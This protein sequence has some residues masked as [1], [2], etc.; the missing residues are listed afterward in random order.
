MMGICI[1]CD[2]KSAD[3]LYLE[4]GANRFVQAV[5]NISQSE[6]NSWVYNINLV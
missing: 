5:G 3:T 2:D 6:I 4:K 1:Y